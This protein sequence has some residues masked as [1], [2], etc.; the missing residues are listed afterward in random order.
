MLL[1]PPAL[2]IGE[3]EGF[4]KEKDI[5]GRSIIGSGLTNIVSRVTDPLVIAIDNEWGTGKTAFL[6]MWAGELRKQEIPV[7]FFDAFQHDYVEDAFTAI[8]GE[9]VS[10]AADQRKQNDPVTRMFVKS[11]VN[12]ARVLLRSGLKIGV[13]LATAGAMD[14]AD[15]GDAAAEIA[16]E[17]SDLED[18]YLGELITK[19]RKEKEALQS[20]R[21]ALESLPRLFSAPKNNAQNTPK[22]MP[23]IIIIDELD[24]CRPPFALQILERIKHFFSVSGVHFVLGTHLGQLRNSVIAIYGSGIDAAKYLQKFI[25]F[26]LHLTESTT[27][28]HLRTSYIYVDYLLA[29]MM[30]ETEFLDTVDL[31]REYCNHLAHHAGLSLRSIEKVVSSLAISLAYRPKNLFCPDPILVGLC[32]LKELSPELYVQAKSGTKVFQEAR[33]TLGFVYAAEQRAKRTVDHM[34]KVW[35]YY[36]DP[37]VTGNEPDYQDFREGYWHS[38]LDRWEVVPY[39]ARNVVDRLTNRVS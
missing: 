1:F 21:D 34:T 19:Q 16:K 3:Q 32:A 37:A 25:S 30:P 17:A 7:I 11:S 27:Q 23:L 31:A 26:T 22:P 6:K 38:N 28:P 36:A 29:K 24:R 15:V 8:A 12:A 2:E 9:I 39:V 14:A 20:F 33:V 13:K 5:F 10:L 4:T 18:K 35:R